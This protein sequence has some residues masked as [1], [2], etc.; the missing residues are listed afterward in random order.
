MNSST[1]TTADLNKDGKSEIITLDGGTIKVLDVSGRALNGWPKTI[2]NGNLQALPIVKDL[3]GDGYP[4]ILIQDYKSNSVNIFRR[5]GTMLAS[6]VPMLSSQDAV[7]LFR[8]TV[9]PVDLDGD[10]VSEILIH[11]TDAGSLFAFSLQGALYKGK[12]IFAKSAAK[13]FLLSV[14]GQIEPSLAEAN[15]DGSGSKKIIAVD[16]SLKLTGNEGSFFYVDFSKVSTVIDL[17]DRE[18]R[19]VSPWPI[20][21]QGYQDKSSVAVADLNGD[22]KDEIIV[23]VQDGDTVKIHALQ[24]DGSE[25]PHWPVT[26]PSYNLAI[27][28]GF[29]LVNVSEGVSIGDLD[30]DGSPELVTSVLSSNISDCTFAISATG[31]ILKNW[32]VCGYYNW[33][34]SSPIIANLD[35]DTQSEILLPSSNRLS[36]LKVDGSL[37]YGY[38]RQTSDSWGLGGSGCTVA[39][40]DGDH[41]NEIVCDAAGALFAWNREACSNDA[42]EWPSYFHSAARDVTYRKSEGSRC[43]L[44]EI[45]LPTFLT[46]PLDI[47]LSL[48]RSVPPKMFEASVVSRTSVAFSWQKLGS[49]GWVAIDGAKTSDFTPYSEGTYRLLATN[50]G[51][52]SIS[53]NATVYQDKV[54]LP[55]LTPFPSPVTTSPPPIQIT[56]VP[57]TTTLATLK[58]ISKKIK[59]LAASLTKKSLR[60]RRVVLTKLLSDFEQASSINRGKLSQTL[61][62]RISSVSLTA[63]RVLSKRKATDTTIRK[64]ARGLTKSASA[65]IRIL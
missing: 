44:P 2:P 32:P 37:L 43:V 29:Q 8:S 34:G 14:F 59:K 27:G 31:A 36:A 64:R 50:L 48:V 53:R 1:I 57:V 12:N 49:G 11:D 7:K 45:S 9:L 6:W 23:R 21:L 58:D 55:T 38:P 17:F 3:D 26:L 42:E 41:R 28:G 16:R 40:L 65:L 62:R 56:T 47:P 54:T 51:G 24:S 18:G 19:E 46:Q 10:G 15:I 60:T 52:T 39:D 22:G 61:L 4:E 5:D 63:Q 33:I 25:L 35:S 30:N 13:G 20:T